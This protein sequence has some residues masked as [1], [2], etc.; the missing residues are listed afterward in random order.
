MQPHMQM[1]MRQ[2]Q[3]VRF[4]GQ[5]RPAGAEAAAGQGKIRPIEI[6]KTWPS[7]DGG[8]GPRPSQRGTP[9]FASPAGR[10]S[11]RRK[12]P[13]QQS[14]ST[15]AVAPPT[16]QIAWNWTGRTSIRSILT[17]KQASV[18]PSG[19]FLVLPKSQ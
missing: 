2:R 9:P 6:E 4:G 5:G 15:M 18:H 3:N 1:P 19:I 13:D 8:T 14:T 12:R 7:H 11:V 10:P 17:P 16:W